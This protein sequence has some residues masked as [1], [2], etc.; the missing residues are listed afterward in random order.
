[1]I[2]H[3]PAAVTTAM[4]VVS[5]SGCGGDGT[6]TLAAATTTGSRASA[7]GANATGERPLTSSTAI[8]AQSTVVPHGR[9]APS[10]AATSSATAAME[11]E[12]VRR[13]NDIRQ[14]RGLRPLEGHEQLAAIARD[15]SCRM[16][17]EDFFSHASPMGGTV[18]DRAREAGVEYRL[19]GENL[20]RNTNAAEPVEVAVQGWMDSAGHRENILREGFTETG[21]GI[22]RADERYYFTQVFLQLRPAAGIAGAAR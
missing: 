7:A 1:M 22:C 20:A 13:I 21:V 3:W 11:R 9:A 15:Y 19:I 17:R 14:E 8:S 10:P 2:R 5:L 18:A 12:V 4:L 6:A 16:A